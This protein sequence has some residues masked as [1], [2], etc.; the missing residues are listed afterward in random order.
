MKRKVRPNIVSGGT[1]INLGNNL[2]YM[3]GKTHKQGGIDIGS[4][5]KTGIEVEN[6]EVVQTSPTGLRVF[7]AQPILNGISPANAL[8]MGGNPNNIFNAQEAWKQANHYNDDGTKFKNG[9]D[10]IPTSNVKK[11]LI[12]LK[13][14]IDNKE[15]IDDNPINKNIVSKNEDIERGY[16]YL[17]KGDAGLKFYKKKGVNGIIYG[18]S[19]YN[20]SD[21]SDYEEIPYETVRKMLP[22]RDYIGG[23]DYRQRV[24][25]KVPGLKSFIKAKAEEYGI[26]PNLLFHR[27]LREGIV[28][29]WT[30]IYNDSIYTDEQESFFR[31]KA[32]KMAV[33]GFGDLGLDD[34][35]TNLLEGKY[36]LKNPNITW[37][38]S[39]AE[40]E[41]G[42][43]VKSAIFNNIWDGIEVKAAEMA[44]RQA[45]LAK[46]GIVGDQFVNAAY[47]MGLNH[48]DL[49]NTDYVNKY[50]S[51]P[52][53]FEF[54]GESKSYTPS[55]EII[56]YIKKTEGFR[57]KWYK[58]G[59]GIDTIGYGFTG[60]RIKKL[61]P[62]GITREQADKEF[63][64]S[65]VK[66]A[67]I[68]AKDTPNWN[69]LS[70][71][72][73]DALLSYHYNVGE[74][75]YRNKHKK[76]QQALADS[77]WENVV[78]NMDAGYNDKK[79]PGLRTRRDYERELFR[80]GMVASLTGD[81][82]KAFRDWYDRYSRSQNLDPNPDAK[83]HYYDYRTYWKNRTP[84]EMNDE[85]KL[86]NHLPDTYKMP[87]N[88]TF[89]TKSI[90]ST[91]KTP[92]G[93]WK[94][95]G[96]GPVYDEQF[97]DSKYTRRLKTYKN[98][99]F[100]LGGT[101]TVQK[102]DTLTGIAKK[103]NIHYS[104]LLSYNR[105]IANPNVIRI[106]Q[107]INLQDN[108]EQSK[109]QKRNIR[110]Y[111]EQEAKLNLDNVSAIQGA[112]HKQNYAIIDKDAKTIK[113]YDINNNLLYESN[114]I[115]TGKANTD[116]NTVTYKHKDTKKLLYGE[117]NNATPAGI[118][119]I[120]SKASYHGSP[121]F[122]RARVDGN[123][124]ML[125]TKEGLPDNIP[126][127]I[128]WEKGIAGPNASNGCVRAD[129]KTLQ[130]LNKYLDVGSMVYTL[131]QQHGSSFQLR[132]GRLNFVDNRT[133]NERNDD[134]IYRKGYK[135]LSD[136]R[137]VPLKY[138]R[139]INTVYNGTYLPI[140]IED[141]LTEQR[142][143]PN[144][145][146]AFLEDLYF[147][148]GRQAVERDE[149]NGISRFQEVKSRNRKEYADSIVNNKEAIMRAIPGLS[150]KEYNQLITMAL[151][152]PERETHY[153]TDIKQI[154]T[155][156]MS[157]SMLSL[158]RRIKG[159]KD[160]VRSVGIGKIKSAAD[161]KEMRNIYSALGINYTDKNM[162]AEDSAKMVMS[163]LAYTYL[164]EIKGRTFVDANGNAL[165][166]EQ[167]LYY[168][169][170]GNKKKKIR[171]NFYQYEKNYPKEHYND[172]MN[173]GNEFNVTQQ[174]KYGGIHIKPSKRGTFTAAA[175]RHHMSVQEFARTVLNN[176]ARYSA[177]MVKKANF[178]RNASKWHKKELGGNMTKQY[179][180]TR[181]NIY[182]LGGKV[183]DKQVLGFDDK[184]GLTGTITPSIITDSKVS[185]IEH[186]TNYYKLKE[187][188]RRRRKAP[189]GTQYRLDS[190]G[191]L[192]PINI[193]N[194]YINIANIGEINKLLDPVTVIDDAPVKPSIIGRAEVIPQI[195]QTV[196]SPNSHVIQRRLPVS[197][198]DIVNPIT[199]TRDS[200][201]NRPDFN[202]TM[203]AAFPNPDF[204]G[205]VGNIKEKSSVGT[206]P[207]NPYYSKLNIGLHKVG[208]Y[209]KD[210]PDL[211]GLG[212]NLTGNLAASL[213]NRSAIKGMRYADAP[214]PI[215]AQKLPTEVNIEPQV[216]SIR[217]NVAGQERLITDNT[218]DSRVALARRQR[219]RNQ[220]AQQYQT[221]FGNK[222]NTELQLLTA[223]RLNRQGVDTQNVTQYNQ[224]RR[225]LYDFENR[226]REML[227]ENS[228][229]GIN[230]AAEAIAGE[231]GYFARKEARQ[232][233]L[234]DMALIAATSPNAQ[235]VIGSKEFEDFLRKIGYD[236][237]FSLLRKRING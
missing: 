25:D 121:S 5:P 175:K 159:Q 63:A 56:D 107:T 93:T 28:D 58:D 24:V 44:Y 197:I 15:S 211:I 60:S 133:Q 17:Y 156:I 204:D 187:F 105:D 217:E 144:R 152:I 128:H 4:N 186:I 151:G 129:S 237:K 19:K 160:T 176:R 109:P 69:K 139:D 33:S 49:N 90:Y 87:G 230:N 50:Y 233:N 21:L 99:S 177:A 73:R 27:F 65:I 57:D 2:Y 9:G 108:S 141:T 207:K 71:K 103:Y 67:A 168:A 20:E 97:V 116:Y 64:D 227:A 112:K 30:N 52:N 61:Y 216:S 35:G 228:V 174:F 185:P 138:H 225:G 70:Q 223:D 182:S 193:P 224:W 51:V 165:T 194:D 181:N 104:Q 53:Y 114:K 202:S 101:H 231:R 66:R 163:K 155:N 39:D 1:A 86:G 94:Q 222:L 78:L 198:Q 209:I 14:K 200:A 36:T 147:S 59:N 213:I 96:L 120:S 48:K 162:N 131:P 38:E 214:I 153:G 135:T 201:L 234:L 113:V 88:P 236:G 220:G 195:K 221:L 146:K 74:G 164:N 45:E 118:T 111:Y 18:T 119:V 183:E 191:N 31:D 188:L 77:D 137:T 232:Q 145:V 26:S 81:E 79:N 84:E 148:P 110:E 89:S 126:S 206:V 8:L 132:D 68:L 219:V 205:T 83:G 226:R 85:W 199:S 122:Q 13:N 91:R 16:P 229:A 161:N 22:K 184:L 140:G 3:R 142:Q 54:G 208:N 154:A 43:Q 170:T 235:N 180:I 166:P 124:N 115:N 7:S 46:R 102:G 215:S 82:E 95:V 6:G 210:N 72:Q 130:E 157:D 40:N 123:G 92:G 127:S 100:E 10:D 179:Y 47:N 98:V 134:D 173:Y 62:N 172:I 150:N 80:S 136:G 158:A 11:E 29:K 189:Y 55:K 171:D 149:A 169:Y 117:G 192:V 75:S 34:V 12:K 178:A 106:G 76:L 212:V 42:R 218:A 143:N 125:F 32:G 196:L 41:H 37:E 167:A 203:L 190:N 23:N